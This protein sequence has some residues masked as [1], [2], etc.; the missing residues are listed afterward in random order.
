MSIWPAGSQ[1]VLA[2]V[3]GWKKIMSGGRD[4]R[5]NMSDSVEVVVVVEAAAG[6]LL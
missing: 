2:G 1:V 3:G 6:V 5:R 4:I